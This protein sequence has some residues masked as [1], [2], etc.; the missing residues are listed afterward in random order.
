IQ[1][2]L[3]LS[4]LR[5]LYDIYS[6]CHPDCPVSFSKFAQLR[7]KHCI[8]AGANGTHSVCVCTIHQN[9]KLM[10]DSVNLNNLTK[11]SNVI[12]HDYKDCLRQIVCKNPDENC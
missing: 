7:P 3:L 6:K 5:G 10:I 2:R 11:D 12:L 9:C 1:K 8:L 4:D